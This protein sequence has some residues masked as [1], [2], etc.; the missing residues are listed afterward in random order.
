MTVDAHVVNIAPEDR[1]LTDRL[2]NWVGDIS[3]V[4][5]IACVCGMLFVAAITM[6]DVLLRWFAN[7]PI[8][9]IN[10]IVQMTFSVAI[11][12]CI[13]AGM[14]Q[15]VNLKIDLVARYFTPATRAWLEVLGSACL[16]LFYG[17]LAWRIGIYAETLASEGRTTVIL[18]LPQAPFM[19][20]VS[21]LLAFGT[22]V[23]TLIIINEA[24][25]AIVHGMG[26]TLVAMAVGGG[27]PT[28][29]CSPPG[30]RLISASR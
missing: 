10:E 9:A 27:S 1:T 28:K 15:R 14:I 23:Q 17:V 30:H 22:L 7:E 25:R 6:V 3:R 13:P 12:A 21:L 2:E 26:S 11:S 19:Y 29:R 8:P 24:R 4:V 16:W 5:A 20:C 18:G